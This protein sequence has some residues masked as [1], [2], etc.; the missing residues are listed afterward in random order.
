MCSGAERRKKLARLN[1]CYP[2]VIIAAP[3][4]LVMRPR[5][6]VRGLMG[7]DNVRP[8]AVVARPLAARGERR[9]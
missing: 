1:S 4:T 7:G 8:A 3:A 6:P 2:H 5:S 9:A